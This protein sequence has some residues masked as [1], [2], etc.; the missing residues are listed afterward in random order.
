MNQLS[1]RWAMLAFGIV[2][3]NAGFIAVS[4]AVVPISKQNVAQMR[5]VLQVSR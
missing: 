4:D 3:V 5:R 1:Q 2:S